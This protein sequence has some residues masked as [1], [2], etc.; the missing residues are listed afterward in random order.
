MIFRVRGENNAMETNPV[1]E[2]KEN[3]EDYIQTKLN[4]IKLKTADKAGT[5]I[6]GVILSVAVARLFLFIMI[7]LSFAAA[8][9]ISQAT[10][11]DY[12]GFLVVAG[13]YIAVAAV[14]II[15]REKLLTMPIINTLLRKLNYKDQ[16]LDTTGV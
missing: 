4:L 13:F 16:E 6:S 7:F 8:Y 1:K 10:G 12:L 15:F 14:L 9:A 3:A 11:Q 2:V 5:A